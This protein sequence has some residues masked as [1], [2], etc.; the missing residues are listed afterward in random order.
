MEEIV[1][2]KEIFKLNLP[3]ELLHEVITYCV[4]DR[5]HRTSF[6]YIIAS[7]FNPLCFIRAKEVDGY[8]SYLATDECDDCYYI[9][10]NI[11][12]DQLDYFRHIETNR[13][14]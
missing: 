14:V 12:M 6:W 10:N 13:T 5:P 2:K 9:F 1:C 7:K 11:N 4:W 3:I 8:I